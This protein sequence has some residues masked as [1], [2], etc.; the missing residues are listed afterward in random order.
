MT[1]TMKNPSWIEFIANTNICCKRKRDRERLI[2]AII[3]FEPYVI[4]PPPFRLFQIWNNHPY[5][6]RRWTQIIWVHCEWI[7]PPRF[8]CNEPRFI[9]EKRE[10]DLPSPLYFLNH[11]RNSTIQIIPNLKQSSR[12]RRMINSDYLGSLWM[13]PTI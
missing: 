12:S 9:I 1:I 5:L 6:E 2:V 3:Y 13:N 4:M 7:Q 10:N 11:H 8:M